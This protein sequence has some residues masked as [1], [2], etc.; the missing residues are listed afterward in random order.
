MPAAGQWVR[1][2]DTALAPGTATTSSAQNS[3]A[4]EW[5]GGQSSHA[6]A[7]GVYPASFLFAFLS[8]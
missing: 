5:V 4:S 8:P 7:H 1:G 6:P 3:N 2:V